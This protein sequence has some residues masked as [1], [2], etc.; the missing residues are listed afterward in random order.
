MTLYVKGDEIDSHRHACRDWDP[1]YTVHVVW[2]VEWVSG[3]FQR[4][5]NI[6]NSPTSWQRKDMYKN[7][8]SYGS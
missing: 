4:V 2:V 3:T 8:A 1:I 7:I 5:I 6:V